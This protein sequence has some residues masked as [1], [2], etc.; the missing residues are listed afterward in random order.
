MLSP[1]HPPRVETSA[2]LRGGA[3][4]AAGAQNGRPDA[5]AEV[6]RTVNCPEAAAEGPLVTN[7]L[8]MPVATG[9]SAEVRGA[10]PGFGGVARD[11]V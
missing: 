6:L 9:P 11:R 8:R 7:R 1:R 3:P 5:A 4:A 10:R 2:R